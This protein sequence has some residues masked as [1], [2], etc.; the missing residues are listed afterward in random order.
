MPKEK[1]FS[2]QKMNKYFLFPFFVPII[3]FT[4]KFF[5][6]TM[7]TDGETIDIKDVTEDNSN[8]FVFL[9]LLIQ[10]ICLIFG[11]LL[12]FIQLRYL[13]S[14]KTEIINERKIYQQDNTQN[15]ITAIN[16]EKTIQQN[17]TEND[18]TKINNVITEQQ[19]NTQKNINMAENET[20]KSLDSEMESNIK[21]NSGKDDIG[22]VSTKKCDISKYKTLI[23]II[24]MPLLLT[25]YNLGKAYAVGYPKLEKRIYFLFFITLINFVLFKKQIYRHQKL[26][27]M[28]TLIGA[29]FLYISF[30]LNFKAAQYNLIYDIDLFIGSSFYSLYL[31]SFKYLTDNK[32]ISVFLLLLYQ[33]I[34]CLVYTLIIY[35]IISLYIKGDFTYITNIFYCNENNYVCI[36]RFYINIIIYI[37]LN[38]ILQTFIFLVVYFFS[39][40]LFAIS[41][42][43]SPLFS[44][45]ASC[46]QGK[47]RKG[48]KIF[49]TI[50]GD[51]IIAFGAFIYNEI[52]IC[53]FC[54][55]NENTWKGIDKKAVVESSRTDIHYNLIIDDNYNKNIEMQKDI[56][57]EG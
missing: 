48:I 24:L 30:G 53:N 51:L 42:I 2:F 49:L 7:K 45:I 41:D 54:G 6:E 9:Y 27:L 23:I 20:T 43:F 14:E 32:G 40:E 17:N 29:I 12:Y 57:S 21:P 28:I 18:I 22:S 55:L 19:D 44:F 13:K 47:E 38:T 37:I 26:A 25:L 50:F 56:L 5:S 4:T 46:I 52:I 36:S 8:T 34:L 1:L 11:G 3:C 16:N 31:V 10:G 39:P 33:G 35:I 15:D